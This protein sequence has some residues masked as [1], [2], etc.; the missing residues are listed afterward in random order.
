MTD[1]ERATRGVV[2]DGRE[3]CPVESCPFVAAACPTH[4]RRE[5]ITVIL[6]DGTEMSLED[7]RPTPT[8]LNALR[9]AVLVTRLRH[10]A[11]ALEKQ[12]WDEELGLRS[13]R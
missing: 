1:N 3:P 5:R 7:G 4:A 2:S 11:D 12:G 10:H 9:R 13:V 8:G 6:D